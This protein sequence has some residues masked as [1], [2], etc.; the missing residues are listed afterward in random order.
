MTKLIH[1]QISEAGYCFQVA[2]ESL[3]CSFLN[4]IT[5]HSGKSVKQTVVIMQ[6][7]GI[8]LNSEVGKRLKKDISINK[9]KACP[10]D[11]GFQSELSDLKEFYSEG[12]G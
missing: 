11:F 12:V 8:S 7:W 9:E 3:G 5:Q 6:N 1:L 2:E 10:G 4:K